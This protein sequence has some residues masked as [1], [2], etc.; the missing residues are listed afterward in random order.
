MGYLQ[1]NQIS[2]H[3]KRHYGRRKTTKGFLG[4]DRIELIKVQVVCKSQIS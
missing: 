3:E 1:T 2:V 4:H